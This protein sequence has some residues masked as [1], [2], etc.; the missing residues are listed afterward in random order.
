MVQTES[1]IACRPVARRARRLA[2][3]QAAQGVVQA[4]HR[5][6]AG[7]RVHHVEPG[8]VGGDGPQHGGEH[9]RVPDRPEAP[10]GC[11][12]RHRQLHGAVVPTPFTSKKLIQRHDDSRD[13]QAGQV[14]ARAYPVVAAE[15]GDPALGSPRGGGLGADL[16]QPVID[17]RAAAGGVDHQV[18][19]QVTAV[20]AHARH[21]RRPTAGPAG[22]GEQPG[23]FHPEPHR[24]PRLGC[25]RPLQ[26]PVDGGPPGHHRGKP[27]IPRP[28]RGVRQRVRHLRPQRSF[29]YPGGQQP[30][31]YIGQP[32]DEK[33][34]GTRLRDDAAGRSAAPKWRMLRR[35]RIPRPA[36]WR[37]V[38]L[39]DQDVV[40]GAGQ[41]QSGEQACDTAPR[42]DD[43]HRVPLSAPAA[44]PHGVD[45]RVKRRQPDQ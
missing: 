7:D 19:G 13:Q 32:L 14:G 37:G 29:D 10:V 4:A 17:R 35:R 28:G 34:I 42:N 20:G 27:L 39:E 43:I 30:R 45:T 15:I 23:D 9:P 33:P 31:I 1:P 8:R 22:G 16:G 26:H 21:V 38:P 44:A 2:D 11:Q 24:D 3:H 40:P 36:C 25:R 41:Q 18:G 12:R 6:D 5:E